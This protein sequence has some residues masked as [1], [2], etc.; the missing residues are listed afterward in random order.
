M[1]AQLTLYCTADIH[2][3]PTRL[4]DM[5]LP[6]KAPLPIKTVCTCRH[7]AL[8]LGGIVGARSLFVGAVQSVLSV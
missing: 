7:R 2:C 8:W 6:L 4:L 3:P 5:Q 1:K